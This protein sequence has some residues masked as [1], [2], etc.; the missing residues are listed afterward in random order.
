MEEEESGSGAVGIEK[1][2]IE[3]ARTEEEAAGASRKRSGWKLRKTVSF[4]ARGGKGLM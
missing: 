4:R 2:S 3:T 1:L